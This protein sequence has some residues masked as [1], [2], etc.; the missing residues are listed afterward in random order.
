[1]GIKIK[2]L[3]ELQKKLKKNT[4]MTEVKKTVKRN[5]SEL[6]QKIEKNA[7]F[8]K[9]YQTGQTKKSIDLEIKDSGLT[10]ESGPKT[11]YAGYIEFGT[12]HMEAQPFVRPALNEQKAI[13]KKDL[14]KL[15]R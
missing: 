1:M 13:F 8:K 12:R 15:T 7:D 3:D 4:T 6:Q 14:K 9:G 2:G 11:E 5:G 10:A